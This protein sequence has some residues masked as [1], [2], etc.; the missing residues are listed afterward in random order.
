MRATDSDSDGLPAPSVATISG[1][2]VICSLY[3]GPG[4]PCRAVAWALMREGFA[5]T[6]WDT[7]SSLPSARA[8]SMLVC[9]ERVSKRAGSGSQ[10]MATRAMAMSA[11]TMQMTAQAFARESAAVEMPSLR[12]AATGTGHHY[13]MEGASSKE[14][15]SARDEET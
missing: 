6:L 14:S 7:S 2:S 4:P 12:G 5:S 3:S 8:V 15:S 10:V 1:D 11:M 9:S 13:E